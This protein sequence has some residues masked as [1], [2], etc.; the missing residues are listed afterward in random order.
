MA[1]SFPLK[2]SERAFFAREFFSGPG[3]Y[4]RRGNRPLPWPAVALGC[5]FFGYISFGQAKESNS[6]AEAKHNAVVCQSQSSKH[7]K[8]GK[9][10]HSWWAM[11]N[12]HHTDVSRLSPLWARFLE[13]PKDNTALKDCVFHMRKRAVLFHEARMLLL[14]EFLWLQLW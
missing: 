5:L 3:D 14:A 12:L 7:F 9:D 6:P 10:I 4:A 8:S 1:G 11:P 13:T 2:L